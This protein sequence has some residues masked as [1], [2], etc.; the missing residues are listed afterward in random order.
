MT[1]KVLG[2]NPPAP[3]LPS[4]IEH[5]IADYLYSQYD[6][7]ITSVSVTSIVWEKWFTGSSGDYGIYFQSASDMNVS[8]D[9][10]WQ[11]KDYDHFTD[12]H[13]F[14][15]SLD[16]EYPNNSEEILGKFERWIKKVIAQNP[17]GLAAKGLQVMEVRQT[18]DILAVSD[19]ED[20][21]RKI[22]TIWSR[23]STG[24]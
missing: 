1:Y 12:V 3:D 23:Y 20:I 14:V 19:I 4:S 8:R 5:M 6:Q 7:S 11:I 18:R 13:V 9:L 15:R 24:S 17:T 22:I 21:K 16:N 10:T 2:A